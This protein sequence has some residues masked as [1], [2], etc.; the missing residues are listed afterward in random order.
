MIENEK[1]KQNMKFLIKVQLKQAIKGI[2]EQ[3]KPE[4]RTV[5]KTELKQIQKEQNKQFNLNKIKEEDVS[6]GDPKI[7]NLVDDQSQLQLKDLTPSVL[8]E[9]KFEDEPPLDETPYE[10]SKRD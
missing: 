5:S 8:D 2:R 1:Q 6:L 4:K 10:I 3:R 7:I 9:S